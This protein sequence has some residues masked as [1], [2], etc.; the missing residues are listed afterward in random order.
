[1]IFDRFLSG[2]HWQR[3]LSFA[4]LVAHQLGGGQAVELHWPIGEL[5]LELGVVEPISRLCRSLRPDGEQVPESGDDVAATDP[6]RTVSPLEEDG[7]RTLINT[8]RENS[9]ETATPLVWGGV[10]PR[11]PGFTGRGE[12]LEKLHRSLSNHV[13]SALVAPLHGFGGIGKSHIATEFAYRYRAHY[14]LIWWIQA[15]DELSVPITDEPEYLRALFNTE[16]TWAAAQNEA[17]T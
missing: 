12:V 5:A 4:E 11:N 10:P 16:S 6:Q 13:T 14:D 2:P 8:E 1:V 15:D 7:V 3:A 17:L 9:M